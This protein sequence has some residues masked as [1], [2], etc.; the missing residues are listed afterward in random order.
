MSRHDVAT[1][2]VAIGFAVQWGGHAGRLWSRLRHDF[3][4]VRQGIILYSTP[5]LWISSDLPGTAVSGNRCCGHGRS[6]HRDGRRKEAYEAPISGTSQVPRYCTVWH[7]ISY[8]TAMYGNVRQCMAMYSMAQYCTCTVLY[9]PLFL[10]LPKLPLYHTQTLWY[11]AR[12]M[13]ADTRG[14]II[15]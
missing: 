10:F 6:N 5:K 2:D 11:D 12:A 15:K 7:P 8:C 4:G 14:E 13:T 1:D 9:V 3:A